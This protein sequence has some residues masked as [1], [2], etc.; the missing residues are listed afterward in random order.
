MD[1]NTSLFFQTPRAGRIVPFAELPNGLPKFGANGPYPG[2]CLVCTDTGNVYVATID[3][4]L[5]PQAF[6]WLLR[7]W[8]QIGRPEG[9]LSFAAGINEG[10]AIDVNIGG[11]GVVA[12]T[13]GQWQGVALETV[14]AG[15]KARVAF[16]GVARVLAG[17]VAFPAGAF[18]TQ[19]GGVWEAGSSLTVGAVP[20]DVDGSLMA[21][22]LEDNAGNVL[23][24]AVLA[25][26]SLASNP[27]A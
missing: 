27:T 4:A 16:G 19:S 6:P 8:Q 9:V 24:R 17:A 18:I 13:P 12:A 20:P 10:E 11:V 1:G 23:S 22:A 7:R 5:A 14:G 3:P 26:I 25:F 21:I 15:A 2:D